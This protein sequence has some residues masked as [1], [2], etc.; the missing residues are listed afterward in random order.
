MPVD[1]GVRGGFCATSLGVR[2]ASKL[3]KLSSFFQER[4]VCPCPARSQGQRFD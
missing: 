4:Q 1:R 3:P 2:S